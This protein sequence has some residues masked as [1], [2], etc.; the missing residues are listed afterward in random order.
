MTEQFGSIIY[1]YLAEIEQKIPRSK[2]SQGLLYNVK[3]KDELNL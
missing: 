1:I 2:I 3:N